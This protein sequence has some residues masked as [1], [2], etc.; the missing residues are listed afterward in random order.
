M[1]TCTTYGQWLRGDRR[2][3]V[4]EGRILPANLGL[5]DGGRGRLVDSPWLFTEPQCLAA[6]ALMVESLKSRMGVAVWA[7]CVESWHAHA[8][9]D[10]AGQDIAK[11][12]KCLKDAVRYGLKPGRRVWA[13]GYDKRWCFD[14]PRWGIGSDT[15]SGTTPHTHMTRCAF[16]AWCLIRI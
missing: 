10:P 5:E 7:L 14:V 13:T 3:W 9:V 1:V 8:V 2:G 6:G 4:D 12:V 15:C 16:Q 11:V